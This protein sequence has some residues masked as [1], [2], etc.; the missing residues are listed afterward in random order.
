MIISQV[1]EIHKAI[2]SKT[3]AELV[4]AANL[5]LCFSE[6]PTR[7]IDGPK[8]EMVLR[9][10]CQAFLD[11]DNFLFAG[12]LLFPEHLFNPHPKY[13]IDIVDAY[14]PAN[15]L[16]LQGSNGVAKSWMISILAY[17]EWWRDPEYTMVKVAAV[18]EPHL[19][20]TLMA[21]I[22]RFHQECALPIPNS[23]DTDMYVGLKDGL[24]DMG[25]TGVLFPQGQD[26]S[27][28]IRGYRPKPIRKTLHPRF[29]MMSRTRFFGDEGQ[30][31]KEGPFKDFG[32]LQSAMNG[33]DPVKI[34]IAY[35]PDGQDKPV[36]KQAMP[37]Q[38]WTMAD[39]PILYKWKSKEG[40]DVLRLDGALS[41]NVVARKIIFPGLQTLEGYL[42]FVQAGGDTSAAY[43]CNARGWPPMK[44]AVNIV[45]QTEIPNKWRGEANFIDD[46]LKWGT[47]D[48][49]YQGE[50]MT[51]FTTGRYGLASGWT[52]QHGVQIIFV[53]HEDHKTRQPK[54]ILQYDQQFEIADSSDTVRL[55][56]EI[57]R[58]CENLGIAPEHCGIDATGNG[59][60]TYSHLKT[61]WGAVF[62]IFW[63][64]K[65][66]DIKVLNE[67]PMPASAL[68]GN[69]I[70]EMWFTTRRWL[71]AGV[72]VISPLLGTN[73]LFQQLTQRRYNKVRGTLLQ[74]ET[75]KEYRA[76]GNP[77]PDQADSF[78]QAPF[79]IRHVH[80]ILPG[81]HVESSEKK[82]DETK[83]EKDQSATPEYLETG[84][85]GGTSYLN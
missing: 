85:T 64:I 32:S 38:G 24:P 27:G 78:I 46:P 83:D 26:G 14:V 37:I 34:V 43:Y 66:T 53:S 15:M 65:A 57:Q 16:L 44:G 47:T 76:R 5:A 73:P 45:I 69:V 23:Y 8:A 79:L 3:E 30:S 35:N 51:I 55:A 19:K 54:H 72:I 75:K 39:F 41:E 2:G 56:L 50:D 20:S 77:S 42:K 6:T 11:D 48:C 13:T 12:A 63:G 17:L 28:R 74:V 61:Y 49:S 1:Q 84:Q 22:R 10:M 7:V 71:E 82:D 81:V 59:F 18:N 60:G 31:W 80:P 36:V 52:D 4:S 33:P 29:G 25:I 68:Y 58:L 40:W 21:N 67:D 9:Q 70:S 62:P